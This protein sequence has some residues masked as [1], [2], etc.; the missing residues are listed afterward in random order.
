VLAGSGL[1]QLTG[2]GV[3]MEHGVNG[4]VDDPGLETGVRIAKGYGGCHDSRVM[5][6]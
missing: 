1:L 4:A 6:R 5:F 2:R 3:V